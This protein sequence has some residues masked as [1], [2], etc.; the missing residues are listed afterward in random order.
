MRR[1]LSSGGRCGIVMWSYMYVPGLTRSTS[2][3]YKMLPYVVTLAVLIIV[4]L[5]KKREDQPPASLGLSFFRE[6]R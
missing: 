2:E 1:G 5:R 6:E 3:L 4:S